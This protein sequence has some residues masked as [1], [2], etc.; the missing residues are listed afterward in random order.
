MLKFKRE[1]TSL[2]SLCI[3]S[4]F[5]QKLNCFIYCCGTLCMS[6]DQL[7]RQQI[8][9]DDLTFGRTQFVE[10]HLAAIQWGLSTSSHGSSCHVW[11]SLAFIK[12]KQINK[13]WRASDILTPSCWW[14]LLKSVRPKMFYRML[15]SL[16]L[17]GK[18]YGH[19]NC[20]F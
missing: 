1:A 12:L 18:Y 13:I 8:W 11:K 5:F 19:V 20:Y 16:N 3:E 7:E 6:F 10:W 2:N 9:K 15:K 4:C 14:D 17:L